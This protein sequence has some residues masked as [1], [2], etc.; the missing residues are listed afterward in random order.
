MKTTNEPLIYVDDRAPDLVGVHGRA[1]KHDIEAVARRYGGPPPAITVA[2][3]IVEARYAHP[4][5]HSYMV[6]CVALRDV[7]G[8]PPATIHLPGA[9]HEVMVYALNPEHRRAL[10]GITPFLTPGNFHGQWRAESDAAAACFIEE[11]VQLVID[12]RLSPDTDFRRDWIARFSAS[13]MKGP[14]VPPGLVVAGG[15]G[16]TFVGTGKQNVDT[17][18]DVAAGPKPPTKDMH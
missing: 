12:W 18:I 4:V 9:T 10:N 6:G 1:W 7:P 3:W 14:D 8:V 5:W 2:S 17:L 11:T 15:D 13:N 16:L